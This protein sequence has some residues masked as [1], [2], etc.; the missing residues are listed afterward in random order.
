MSIYTV[1]E[2]PL[3]AADVAPDPDRFAFVRDGFSIWAFLVAALW[4]LY[5]RMWLVLVI[6]LLFAA[7]VEAALYYA[8]IPGPGIVLVQLL[9]ALLVG[10]EAGTLRRFAL[11]RRHWKDIGLVSG[12]TLEEAERRF[13]DAWAREPAAKQNPSS[14]EESAATL[15]MPRVP[16]ASHV[17]GLFPDPGGGP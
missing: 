13:F 3:R 1:H 16:R 10:L 11:K 15:P 5:H 6:Y 7:V 17:I 9:I 8:G 2:P 12:K 14:M 4:M